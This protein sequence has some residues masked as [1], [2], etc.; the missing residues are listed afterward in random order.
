MF[1]GSSMRNVIDLLRKSTGQ[2]VKRSIA[3]DLR[4]FHDFHRDPTDVTRYISIGLPV[5]IRFLRDGQPSFK[6]NSL[7]HVSVPW[8]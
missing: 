5:L 3:T 7:E 2:E 6:K 1:Y 4:D 8:G